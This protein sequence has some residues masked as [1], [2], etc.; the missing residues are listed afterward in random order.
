MD[1]PLFLRNEGPKRLGVRTVL[2]AYVTS[3]VFLLSKNFAQ[4]VL[5]AMVIA[6]PAAWF[7]MNH[8]LEGFAFHVDIHSSVFLLAFFTALIIALLTVSYESVKAAVANPSR[9]LRDE[10]GY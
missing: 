3:V 9:S 5:I 4:P 8:W 6:S 7:A 2:G 1:S 10:Q